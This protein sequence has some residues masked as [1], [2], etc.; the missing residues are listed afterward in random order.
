MKLLRHDDKLPYIG[1]DG[2]YRSG[3]AYLHFWRV[4]G[5]FWSKSL[6][7]PMK[8]IQRGV[9]K[10]RTQINEI[11]DRGMPFVI[12]QKDSRLM[13]RKGIPHEFIEIEASER[14]PQPVSGIAAGALQALLADVEAHRE[15]L[16]HATGVRAPRLGENPAGVNTFAQLALINENDQTKRMEIVNQHRGTIKQLVEDSV[17]DMRR[18]WGAQKQ[19]ML[20]GDEDEAEA[21][22]FNATQIPAFFIVKIAKGASMPR[23]QAANLKR[24]EDIA[25]YSLNA[26]MPLPTG[27]LKESQEAGQPLEIPEESADDQ[28]EKARRENHMLMLGQDVPVSYY[29]PPATHI[30]IH[31]S[32]QIQAEESGDVAAWQ[33]IETH[34]QAHLLAQQQNA[35]EVAQMSAPPPFPSPPPGAPPPPQ[36]GQ[37]SQPMPPQGAGPGVPPTGGTAP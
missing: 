17:Y 33:R 12:V 19:I 1:P 8:S 7:E 9:N 15:D 28:A 5:R 27:W 16:E 37:P 26:R 34:V 13:Q 18:Y 30:P 24:I 22:V 11:I 6:I 23:G 31:R 35:L 10:R 32:A 20:A 21:S 4:T 14:I 3:I 29:D 2:E 25:Q 36:P